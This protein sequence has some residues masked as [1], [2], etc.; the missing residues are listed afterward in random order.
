MAERFELDITSE[1]CPMTF[2]IT[3]IKLAK[4]EK[5]DIVEV[6]VKE[7]EASENLPKSLTEHGY[8]VL[9]T[10]KLGDGLFRITVKK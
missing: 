6:L 9:G 1:V 2:V 7:G 5:G 10:E 8:T 4:M 3:K